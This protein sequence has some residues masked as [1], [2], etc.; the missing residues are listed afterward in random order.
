MANN[1]RFLLERCVAAETE[2]DRLTAEL[3]FARAALKGA[4]DAEPGSAL[5]AALALQHRLDGAQGLVTQVLDCVRRGKI[6]PRQLPQGWVA[7]AEAVEKARLLAEQI[8]Q[9][10]L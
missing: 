2:R 1:V 6:E 3:R 9:T 7:N 5:V 4:I 10:A 8:K